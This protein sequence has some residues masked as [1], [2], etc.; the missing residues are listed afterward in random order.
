VAGFT[1]I[2][3]AYL[4]V[5]FTGYVLLG[6]LSAYGFVY[7]KILDKK[8]IQNADPCNRILMPPSP[9]DGATI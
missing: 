5:K 6:A 1:M 7:S 9:D 8:T 3:T 2:N 4:P